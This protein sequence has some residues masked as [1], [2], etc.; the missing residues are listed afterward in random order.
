MGLMGLGGLVSS[1]G[2]LLFWLSCCGLSPGYNR[3][4][5]RLNVD[6]D[7]ARISTKKSHS[8]PAGFAVHLSSSA[9]RRSQAR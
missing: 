4:L 8:D 2:G 3:L 9:S 7:S 6:S 5:I 1:I